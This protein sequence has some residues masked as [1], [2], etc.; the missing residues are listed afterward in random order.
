MNAGRD[1]RGWLERPR[2]HD[3]HGDRSAAAGEAVRAGRLG[4][5]PEDSGSDSDFESRVSHEFDNGPGRGRDSD[6]QAQVLEHPECA[7]EPA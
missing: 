7:T 5:S 3:R 6:L 1:C 4:P 2:P